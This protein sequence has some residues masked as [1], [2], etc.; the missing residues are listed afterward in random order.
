MSKDIYKYF[1]DTYF[2]IIFVVKVKNRLPILY[3]TVYFK[4]V[5]RSKYNRYGGY[6]IEMNR[7]TY[8]FVR[9]FIICPDISIIGGFI[10]YPKQ[11]FDMTFQW[12]ASHHSVVQ[13]GSHQSILLN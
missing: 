4:E 11:I 10:F 13:F 8:Y 3:V 9:Q 7:S 12:A 6:K 5:Y 2:H 1:M